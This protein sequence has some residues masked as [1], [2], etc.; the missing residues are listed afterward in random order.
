MNKIRE[1]WDWYL[2]EIDSRGFEDLPFILALVFLILI[3]LFGSIALFVSYPITFFIF[4]I[5][6]FVYVGYQYYLHINK[7]EDKPSFY[8]DDH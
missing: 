8:D 4:V 2:D 7:K 5:S 6:V 3:I 1:F